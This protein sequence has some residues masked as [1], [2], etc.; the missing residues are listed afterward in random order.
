MTG[1]LPIVYCANHPTVETTLRCSRCEKPICPKCAVLTPTGYKC[2]D[3]VRSQQKVF[4]NAEWYDYP[5]A[6]AIAG[7]IAF[8]GS[9]L[10][11]ILGFFMIFVAPLV[12]GGIGEIVRIAVRRRRSKLLSQL[13]VIAA[14]LGS[15]I[16]P[17][18]ILLQLILFPGSANLLRLVWYGVYTV[19]AASSLTYRMVGIRVR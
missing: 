17:A 16:I 2:K 4:D 19:L 10:V 12:G 5:I 14:V 13:T 9:L 1:P 11:S 8:L 15:I 7:G 18:G 6:C 3:C